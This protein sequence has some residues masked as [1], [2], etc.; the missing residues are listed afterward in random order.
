[1]TT[2]ASSLLEPFV[3]RLLGRDPPVTIRFWDGSTLGHGDTT[4]AVVSPDAIR[5]LLWAPG[6]LGLGRAYV[7]GALD[8]EGDV[9]A[10]LQVRDTI[11]ES[12]ADAD[13]TLGW[14]G[15]ASLLP[16]ARRLKLLGRR[17]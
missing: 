7:S 12:R 14:G 9:Y 6:E 13:I 15:L 11:A 1:M 16:A 2:T 5:H 17:P 4:I 10:L 3:S 8:L